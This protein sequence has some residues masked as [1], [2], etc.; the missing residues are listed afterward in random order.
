MLRGSI[1]EMQTGEGKTVVAVMAS[2][3]PALTGRGCHVV[4]TNDYL[5]GRDAEFA[6]PVLAVLGLSVGAI[7]HEMTATQRRAVYACDV[8][9]G[10]E[11]EFGF[12]FLRDQMNQFEREQPSGDS[13]EET[14]FGEAEEPVQRELYFALVD[15]A[16]SVLIDQSRTPL[17]ISCPRP[18]A[19]A[20]DTLFR[21][22]HRVSADLVQA[23]DFRFAEGQHSATLTEAGCRRVQLTARP[24]GLDGLRFEELY[25]QV[26]LALLSR[27][28]FARDRQYVVLDE[29]IEI[30]DESTGRILE[31]RKWK[32]GLQQAIEVQAGVPI[33][34]P[35][36]TAARI[37]LQ[38]YFLRYECLGGMT[39]TASTARR[40]FREVYRLPV[41]SIPTHAPCRRVAFPPRVFV[42]QE[43]KLDAVVAAIAAQIALG[44]PVLVG[45]S[46]VESSE[47]LADCLR[48][49]GLEFQLLHAREHRREAE[50]V[51]MA[52][53]APVVTVATN[54]AGRGTDIRLSD[55]VRQAGGLHVIATGMQTSPRIDQ[56]LIGRSARQG[57]PGS[58]QIFV[59]LNDR[60]LHALPE[61]FRRR[62]TRGARP[63]AAGELP[64]SW[65]TPFLRAQQ[66]L[67]RRHA[68][69]RRQQLRHEKAL[70][71]VHRRL[72]LHS[73]VESLDNSGADE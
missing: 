48:R 18:Q 63:D 9:Y 36:G 38:S 23:R 50:I 69:Q 17:I 71:R 61:G 27:M 53:A 49:H 72:G 59:S 33:S 5:A 62:L 29:R 39:G 35:L 51:R 6:R 45:T 19:S 16:D 4:T 26:E 25:R 68:R 14:P 54:L 42:S 22:C 11:R 10:T 28:A 7:Q 47:E 65:V 8:T 46:T 21:W 60:L 34:N 15:E 58:F 57:D 40:E 24:P 20:D 2:A 44:R 1:V 55:E 37:T 43:A 66:M 13:A 67:E 73:I 32:Q 70:W 31:G 41:V 30:V 3:V 52:G 12:D 64:R 56:Q